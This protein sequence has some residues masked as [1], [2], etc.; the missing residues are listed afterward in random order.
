[1]AIGID[2]TPEN[3]AL[4]AAVEARMRADSRIV[5]AKAMLLRLAGIGG[6]VALTGVGAAA[7]MLGYSFIKDE[8]PSADKIADA[9][10]RAL[11]RTTLKATGDFRLAD[12]AKVR[13]D[14]PTVSLDPNAS[15]R[16]D[17]PLRL[18]PQATV[19][20][21]PQAKVQVAGAGEAPRPTPQ[22]LQ[23][24][25]KTAS[26]AK[27][28]TNYT[29]FKSVAFGQGSVVTGWSFTTSEQSAPARQYCYYVQDGAEANA[30][31][32]VDVALDGVMLPNLKT[33]S[34]EP[35][36]AAASCTWFDGKATRA[37]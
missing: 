27:P 35:N 30:Q 4:A 21:D 15:L 26:G 10:V 8:R 9:L 28:V 36:A 24:E 29:I 11:D 33:R 2:P 34:F 1:M 32:K 17:G 13:L 23:Q 22:Q 37:F 12:D 5:S 31:V 20:L 3:Q 6:L 14:N 25:A 7:A 16:V 19:K 18:D